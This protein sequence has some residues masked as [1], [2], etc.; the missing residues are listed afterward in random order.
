MRVPASSIHGLSLEAPALLVDIP[1]RDVTV[2]ELPGGGPGRTMADV[3][4]LLPGGPLGAGGPLTRALFALRGGLGRL[5][6][7][8]R[9]APGAH[10]DRDTSYLSR[11]SAEV[12]ARSQVAPGT[13]EGPVQVLYLL[14]GESLVEIRNATVHAFLCSALRE[15]AGGYALYWAVY[16]KSTSWLSPLYMALIE[17]FRRFVV[18]PSLLAQIR[19][20]WMERYAQPPTSLLDRA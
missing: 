16:V 14:D 9:G 6:G 17:P 4:A 7:W 1:L 5:F 18:Y 20:A 11:L 13:R 3:R 10:D 19:R 12:R 2:I 8:D 15:H